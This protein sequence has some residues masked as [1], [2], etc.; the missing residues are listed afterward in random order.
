VG[1]RLTSY[2]REKAKDVERDCRNARSSGVRRGA[3]GQENV[4][5]GEGLSTVGAGRAVETIPSLAISNT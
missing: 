5:R 2:P 3:R 1:K 4:R